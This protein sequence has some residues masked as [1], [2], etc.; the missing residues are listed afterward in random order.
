[1]GRAGGHGLA[2]A[3]ACGGRAGRSI[4]RCCRWRFAACG[5][6]SQS[7]VHLLPPGASPAA[8]RRGEAADRQPTVADLVRAGPK[9][10][11][12]ESVEQ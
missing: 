3:P 10:E 1:M 7:L 8:R 11:R 6:C 12:W 9:G 2:F 5:S 4:R